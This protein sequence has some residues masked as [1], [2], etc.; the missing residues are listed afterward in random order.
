MEIES[1]I[2]SVVCLD[3]GSASG[4]QCE[5]YRAGRHPTAVE[6][7]KWLVDRDITPHVP[8]GE[9]PSGFRDALGTSS[10]DSHFSCS[11]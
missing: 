10:T 2:R 7:V 8:S 9:H 5:P 3:P 1:Q 11:A 6:K 4:W